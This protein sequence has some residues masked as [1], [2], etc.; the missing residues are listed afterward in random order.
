[1]A[2][3]KRMPIPLYISILLERKMKYFYCLILLSAAALASA[4]SFAAPTRM[5]GQVVVS[6]ANEPGSLDPNFDMAYGQLNVRHSQNVE[7]SPYIGAAGYASGSITFY[8][9]DSEGQQLSCVL[10]PGDALYKAAVDIKNSLT[11]GSTVS[12]QTAPNSS[13]CVSVF[14]GKYSSYLD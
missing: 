9:R 4:V 8:A 6:P 3:H 12:F 5:G 11:N 14:H 1:M 13:K 2:L 10:E 7:G